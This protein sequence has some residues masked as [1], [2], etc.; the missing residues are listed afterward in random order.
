MPN[1]FAATLGARA[2]PGAELFR[3]WPQF[4][5]ERAHAAAAR[6]SV[7]GSFGWAGASHVSQFAQISFLAPA[8]VVVGCWTCP[9]HPSAFPPPLHFPPP[10][11]TVVLGGFFGLFSLAPARWLMFKASRAFNHFSFL[12]VIYFAP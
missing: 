5:Q 3:L 9:S 6:R 7:M 8:L 2:Q 10:V 11:G 12:L 4:Q 1:W